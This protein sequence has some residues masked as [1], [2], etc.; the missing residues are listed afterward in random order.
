MSPILESRA[1]YVS[2][3]KDEVRKLLETLPEDVTL[4]D[5]QYSIYVRERIQR[6]RKEADLG[7]LIEQQEVEHR[8]RRWLDE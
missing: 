5:V 1:V 3:A 7:N 6:A 4:E 2:S 8:M